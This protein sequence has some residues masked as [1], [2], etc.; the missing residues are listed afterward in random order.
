[1]MDAWKLKTKSIVGPL[2]GP[3][4]LITGGVH[5]DEFEPMAAIRRLLETIDPAQVRGRITLVP[6]V[7]EPAFL[8]GERTAE[9]ELDLART[10]PGRDDGST[11]ERIAAA[12][13]RLIR[14][15]DFYIDLHTA[16]TVFQMLPLAGYVLHEDPNILAQQRVMA[17]AFGLPVVW[18]TNGRLQGRS[19]S[20]ARDA[21]VP[22][23]YV[24]NGGGGMC[25]ARRVSEMVEGCRNVARAFGILDDGSLQESTP[26]APEPCRYFIEDDRDQSGHLQVQSQAPVAGYFAPRVALGDVIERGQIIG[27]IT[28]PL[29]EQA[30]DIAAYDSG[31]VLLLRTFPTV[32]AGDPLMVVLPISEPGTATFAREA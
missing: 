21:G 8:R 4:L 25:D 28:D 1:M 6:V 19:L 9:D 15:A 20:I 12:L 7:N 27:T 23:I 2:D 13:S 32:R 22:A 3:H 10:C 30:V 29:G 18:G 31:T 16:G 11:T 17:R 14:E 24:E 26:A 5:G